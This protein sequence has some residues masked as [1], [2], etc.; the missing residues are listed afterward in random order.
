MLYSFSRTSRTTGQDFAIPTLSIPLLI[1]IFLVTLL[2]KTYGVIIG[3]ASFI[4]QPFLITLGIP[5]HLAVAHDIAG[6]NGSTVTG[7]YV[8]GK[9]GHMKSDIFFYTL[10]GLLAGPLA[11][12][13]LLSIVPGEV[14][15]KLIAMIACAGAAY[16]LLRRKSDQGLKERSLPPRWKILAAVYGFLIGVYIGFS[17][18]GGG[19]VSG[20]ILISV[21]GMTVTQSI[22]TKRLI[23]AVPLVTAAIG[24]WY[25]GWLQPVLFGVVFAGCLGGGWLGSHLTLRL[26]E[27]VLKFIF[28]TAAVLMA[29]IILFR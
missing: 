13:W 14:V 27:K 18:A 17:G 12:V 9:S 7:A 20:L 23:H 24:Y 19:V 2:T 8:F 3:G 6:T 25:M 28:L 26:N 21:F 4:L 10:P 11:G 29:G 5:P 16:L 1:A 15:E 22:A